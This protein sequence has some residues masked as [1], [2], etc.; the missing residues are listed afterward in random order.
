MLRVFGSGGYR[1][2]QGT[3][4]FSS[5]AGDNGTLSVSGSTYTY[6]T[7]DGQTWTFTSSGTYTNLAQWSS[8][9]GYETQ[10]YR[11]DGSHRLS[12]ITAIDGALSYTSAGVGTK[13]RPDRK[14][15]QDTTEKV[16]GKRTG[17]KLKHRDNT[18][19][20]GQEADSGYEILR[21]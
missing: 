6:S 19:I 14:T 10:A 11:Y 17:Y 15:W 2:Y 16:L 5:P 21:P 3:S 7:P 1:F 18:K 20:E 9:D 13:D 8:A 12:G 4:T